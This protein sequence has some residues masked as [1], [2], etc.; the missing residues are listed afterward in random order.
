[1]RRKRSLWNRRRDEG[2]EENG[3]EKMERVEMRERKKE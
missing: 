2:G 3:D 1:M